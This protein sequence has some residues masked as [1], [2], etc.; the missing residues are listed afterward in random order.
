M[1][2]RSIL[3]VFA[4]IHPEGATR[5]WL[6]GEPFAKFARRF[7]PLAKRPIPG[8]S[9]ALHALGITKSRRSD[10]DHLMLQLHDLA[11]G[12]Q[13]FQR[14]SPRLEFGFP[15]GTTWVVFSDQVVHAATA[16]QFLLEQTSYIPVE[17]FMDR[18][19]CPLA[20]LEEITGRALA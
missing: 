16:G 12:D 2:G 1:R 13:D 8:A 18:T 6:I 5:D 15:A 11:K 20:V 14:N 7:A 9:A 19:A 3:R 17:G 4:N 10:Y